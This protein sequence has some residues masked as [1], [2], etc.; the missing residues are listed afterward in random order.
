[1]FKI[2]GAQNEKQNE[3]DSCK[4]TD[5]NSIVFILQSVTLSFTFV[6]QKGI[7]LLKEGKISIYTPLFAF[8]AETK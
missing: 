3:S 1:M 4:P 8:L 5:R 6:G 7:I 2:I